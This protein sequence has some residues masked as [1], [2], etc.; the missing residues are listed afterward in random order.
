MSPKSLVSSQVLRHCQGTL[1]LVERKRNAWGIREKKWSLMEWICCIM[2]WNI[3]PLNC[4]IKRTTTHNFGI[5]RMPHAVTVCFKSYQ[6]TSCFN[7]AEGEIQY[8]I[9]YCV[10]RLQANPSYP[11]FPVFHGLFRKKLHST[12]RASCSPGLFE[13]KSTGPLKCCLLSSTPDATEQQFC[14][15]VRVFTQSKHGFI[16]PPDCQG[17]EKCWWEKNLVCVLACFPQ[18]I[19]FL[20]YMWLEMFL[21]VRHFHIFVF[22]FLGL[23]AKTKL[24]YD[25]W[26]L[27]SLYLQTFVWRP[28]AVHASAH[29]SIK[30][31]RILWVVYTRITSAW[32][33]IEENS[34]SCFPGTLTVSSFS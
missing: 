30:W 1:C 29:T 17:K 19:L 18:F 27:T 34:L 26:P 28:S 8:L 20:Q 7:T 24:I 33:C 5:C 15:L 4:C 9:C 6:I 16:L 12:N 31:I 21:F 22:A 3:R 25:C 11:S 10:N 32:P 14:V 23:C 13:D 2:T